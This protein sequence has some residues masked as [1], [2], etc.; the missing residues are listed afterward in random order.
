L[1]KKLLI[2]TTNLF[3]I[4]SLFSGLIIKY[5]SAEEQQ[6]DI[7]IIGDINYTLTNR[8]VKNNRVIGRTFE[9]SVTLQNV[10]N[11][12][13]DELVVNLSD[14]EGFS[15]SNLTYLDPGETKVITFI[16]STMINRDQKITINFFPSDIGIDW[17][18]Y[19]KGSKN[20]LIKIK[21]NDGL[22]ATNTPGFEFLLIILA[23]MLIV[24]VSKKRK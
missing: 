22:T 23:I 12:K 8:L 16:W 1:C 15:L 11:K 14:E 17:N 10:G 19:N 4:I 5:C 9:V 3:L 20:C 7:S 24:I 18:E 13:S 2:I 21:D 6:A